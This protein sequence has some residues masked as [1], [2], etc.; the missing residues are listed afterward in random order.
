MLI[1]LGD[2]HG[3]FNNLKW[4]IETNK[5]TDATIIQVGDFGIGFT[6]ENN[7]NK[8][9]EELNIFLK[10]NNIILYAIRGNHDNPKYF[11]GNHILSNLKLMPDY[12]VIKVNDLN[13]LLVGGAISVDRMPRI[14]ENDTYLKVGD[15]RR[16]W[17]EAEVFVYGEEN[18]KFI[19]SL[20]DIDILVTHTAPSKCNPDNSLGFH[21]IVERFALTDNKLKG[22]LISERKLMDEMFSDLLK[23]NDI[24]YH[25]YGHFHF[26]NIDSFG[27]CAHI[28]LDINELYELR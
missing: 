11:L 20:R 27:R 2:I 9:L 12:S 23:N 25:F 14:V 8:L 16:K 13:M 21:R 22:E 17:W 6:N 3:N 1:F 26:H 28:L 7:D 19:D 24:K 4:Q 5:I 18:K 10:D 15:L